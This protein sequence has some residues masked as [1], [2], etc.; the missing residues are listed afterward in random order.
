M[1]V[2]TLLSDPEVCAELRAYVRS[3]KWSMN[4]QKLAAFMKNEMIPAEAEKYAHHI[5][6]K[7]MPEG[8]KKYLELEL[9]PQVHLK[10]SKGISIST[11]RRWLHREGFRYMEHKKGLYY[12]GHDRPDVLDYHQ[13]EFLP[14]MEKY[15]E[16]LVEYMV[17]DVDTEV[18]KP[19]NCVE[20]LLVLLAQDESTMQAHD[21]EMFSWVLEGE[22]LLKHKGPGRGLHESAVICSTFGWL[23]EASVTV[24]YGK[25]YEGYW[26]GELFVKQVKIFKF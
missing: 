5:V 22:Q 25:N 4:P 11:A 19:R 24:E 9:F 14:L 20:R 23:K 13:N 10:V 2:F 6:D 1:K 3:N 8:L 7:E 12:D 17:G 21:G 18:Y 15:C 26:T 16:R